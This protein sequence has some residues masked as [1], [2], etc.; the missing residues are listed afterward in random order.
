M[1]ALAPHD[2]KEIVQSGTVAIGRGGR[3]ISERALE[4]P[5]AVGPSTE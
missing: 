5:G 4:R 1:A 2:I 3:S